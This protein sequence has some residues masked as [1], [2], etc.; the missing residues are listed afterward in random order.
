MELSV[1][2]LTTIV[3]IIDIASSRGAF[4]GEELEPVGRT[5]NKIAAIAQSMQ[6]RAEQPETEQPDPAE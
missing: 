6:Q 4:R 1:N 5:R 3:S 2:D